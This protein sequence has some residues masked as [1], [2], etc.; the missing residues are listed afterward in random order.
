MSAKVSIIIRTKNEARWIG[1]CL[2]AIS[3][4]KYA[5]YE[6]ILVDNG[7][8][9]ETLDIAQ[10]YKIKILNY[11]SPQGF[12]PGRAINIGINE[13]KGDFIVLI[14]GHCIPKNETWLASL[15]DPLQEERIAGVYGRQEPLSFTPATDKRDLAIVFGLDKKLQVKD[16][17][18]H[19]ANSAI[20]RE[21]LLKYP[22][23]ENC[24]NI[25][26]RIWAQ[27]MINI[28]YKICYEPEASVFHHHGIHHNLNQNRARKISNIIND[29]DNEGKKENLSLAA[30][31]PIKGDPLENKNIS[32]LSKT[33]EIAKTL[34]EIRQIIVSVD[35]KKAMEKALLLG[36]THV[37]LRGLELSHE[38]IGIAEVLRFTLNEY[39]KKFDT[40]SSIILLEE[41]Y[42]N[43]DKEDIK[44]II[45]SYKNSDFDTIISA[46]DETK[47]FY[48]ENLESNNSYLENV[49]TPRK[50]KD[51]KITILQTG[52]ASI[53]SA[54]H[55]R[56]GDILGQKVGF[57]NIKNKINI[58]EINDIKILK[59]FRKS[60]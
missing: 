40:L 26:D 1:Q 32:L 23:D 13:A 57:Y 42:P 41:T 24:T 53:I 33:I 29:L 60:L 22:F 12:K 47:P 44:N 6:I 46:Y 19:N 4:Q 56:F 38:Y 52:Y 50:Y 39:E 8:T 36:A 7:S 3:L 58:M 17:F 15:I 31:I 16:P 54:E 59:D 37:I 48:I 43:R 28:G 45:H 49:F 25:E 20:R 27:K 5:N 2:H 55:I 30:V 10:N 11:H 51:Q 14:S 18:F 34:E 35:N 21:L 9:D